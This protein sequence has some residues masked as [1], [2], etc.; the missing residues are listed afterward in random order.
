MKNFL[1]DILDNFTISQDD[2]QIAVMVFSNTVIQQD[3][4]AF[5]SYNWNANVLK[6]KI[7]QLTYPGEGTATDL[8]LDFALSDVFTPAGGVRPDNEGYPRVTVVLT[9]GVSNNP[10]ATAA[11]AARDKDAG[12]VLFSVGIGASI[13]PTEL[14]TIASPPTCMHVYMLDDFT[15]LSQGFPYELK[16]QT[17]VAPAII[18]PNNS[19]IN[20][21]ISQ[22][23]FMYFQFSANA[24]AGM[25]FQ[26][27]MTEGVSAL[28]LATEYSHPTDV[29]YDF[30]IPATSS[31]NSV[32]ISP[33]QLNQ[34]DI[35][36]YRNAQ[37]SDDNTVTIYCSIKGFDA[38]NNF[39]IS[40]FEGYV[41]LP[42]PPTTSAL[43]TTMTVTQSFGANI[44]AKVSTLFVAIWILSLVYY[45]F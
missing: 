12:L 28:Y 2:Y 1:I 21:V 27:S 35:L 15:G 30:I 34:P 40:T 8:A 13:N 26:L 25:T 32:F 39:S 6:Q 45:N 33:E 10:K 36:A 4:I 44:S 9:D 38:T 3:Y 19:V 29:Q 22:D 7:S 11:S 17:C 31:H 18:Q 16:A 23:Q 42:P 24:S 5:N 14:N 43:P 37:S 20:N 41:Y